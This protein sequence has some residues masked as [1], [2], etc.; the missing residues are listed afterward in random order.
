MVCCLKPVGRSSAV[1]AFAPRRWCQLTTLLSVASGA[2]LLRHGGASRANTGDGGGYATA[3]NVEQRIS[4]EGIELA[5]A[6]C[7]ESVLK[8]PGYCCVGDIPDRNFA[9]AC[10]CNPGWSHEECS[11]KTHT[12]KRP[13]HHC[14]AHLPATNHWSKAFNT[15]ELYTNCQTCVLECKDE[16]NTGECAEYMSDIWAAHFRATEPAEVICS[17]DYLK[18]QLMDPSYPLKVKRVLYTEPRLRDSDSHHQPSDWRVPGVG[19]R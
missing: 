19:G 12:T 17:A 4:T 1:V 3:G 9:G 8:V 16:L 10:E 7:R 11:C 13:C 2:R 5:G 15:S 14:M 18:E 6:S